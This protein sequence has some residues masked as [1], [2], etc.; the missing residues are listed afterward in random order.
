MSAPTFLLAHVAFEA[1]VA[2]P[3]EVATFRC[4][5]EDAKVATL[6]I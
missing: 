5:R 4:F 1:K 3:D 2:T 6:R